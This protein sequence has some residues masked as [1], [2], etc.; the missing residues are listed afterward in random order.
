MDGCAARVVVLPHRPPD[1]AEFY[2]GSFR[3]YRRA[4][5]DCRSCSVP[6]STTSETASDPRLWC[7]HDGAPATDFQSAYHAFAR[8]VYDFFA[9]ISP[10][11]AMRALLRPGF[12]VRLRT[13]R[14][15]SCPGPPGT[16][17]CSR[18]PS[19]SVESS[20]HAAGDLLPDEPVHHSGSDAG[21][22][23]RTEMGQEQGVLIPLEDSRF[24]V[25]PCSRTSGGGTRPQL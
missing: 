3:P 16:K 20:N 2:H 19:D 5:V 12:I 13:R 1:S 6:R 23:E 15:A 22:V 9:S 24:A 17:R 21:A 4:G 7:N 10:C 8:G 11:L 18:S 14:P 25:A